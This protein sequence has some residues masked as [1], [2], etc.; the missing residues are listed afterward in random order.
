MGLFYDDK[1][2]KPPQSCWEYGKESS[3]ISVRHFQAGGVKLN[4]LSPSLS[5]TPFTGVRAGCGAECLSCLEEQTGSCLWWW[6]DQSWGHILHGCAKVAT[7]HTLLPCCAVQL[8]DPKY[9]QCKDNRRV[10]L[11]SP[12]PTT[13]HHTHPCFPKQVSLQPT[14]NV[15]L[16]S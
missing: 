9:T 5:F 12:H 11:S 13:K 7:E 6:G 10:C 14:T 2:H 1:K 15:Q 4:T 8:G 3:Q 16:Y